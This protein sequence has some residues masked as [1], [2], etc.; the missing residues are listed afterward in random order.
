MSIKLE[1]SGTVEV[2]DTNAL[3]NT[4]SSLIDQDGLTISLESDDYSIYQNVNKTLN[5]SEVF[6]IDHPAIIRFIFLKVSKQVQITLGSAV[7]LIK[8]YFQVFGEFNGLI[9]EGIEE[10]TYIRGLFLGK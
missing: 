6:I 2:T 3:V 8:D 10:D 4:A 5:I 7:F 1:V 9:I